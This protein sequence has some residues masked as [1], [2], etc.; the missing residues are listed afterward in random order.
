MSFCLTMSHLMTMEN[1]TKNRKK[2]KNE[3]FKIVIRLLYH[4]ISNHHICFIHYLHDVGNKLIIMNG[5]LTSIKPATGE[6]IWMLRRR[7][8]N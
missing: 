1:G 4:I 8:C 7:T 5:H 2:Y 6:T 3:R